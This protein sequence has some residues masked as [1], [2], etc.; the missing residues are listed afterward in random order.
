MI[1]TGARVNR[2]SE[3][4][5]GIEGRCSA[6]ARA[7]LECLRV[8]PIFPKVVGLLC[9]IAGELSYRDI[10]DA[11]IRVRYRRRAVPRRTAPIGLFDRDR[12]RHRF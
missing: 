6:Q 2:L 10:E 8:D 11:L 4:V 5:A 12:V 7:L 9:Q 3:R 1:E